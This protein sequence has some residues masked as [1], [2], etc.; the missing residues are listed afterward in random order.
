M[1]AVNGFL[2]SGN[3]Y[4]AHGHGGHTT[5]ADSGGG[6]WREYSQSTISGEGISRSGSAPDTAQISRLVSNGNVNT[7]GRARRRSF[8][9]QLISLGALKKWP[10]CSLD[11]KNA[12]LRAAGF[13]REVYL[14]APCEWDSKDDRQVWKLRAPAYARKDA[15]VAVHRSLR[16]YL[17][18]S[19]GSLCSAGPRFELSSFG[20]RL[21]Y[22]FRKSWGAVGAI[23]THIDNISGCGA[24]DLL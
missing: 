4:S 17:V 2:A 19:A 5:D 9:M 1:G 16:K 14:R 12:F 21:Y 7:T 11:I 13:D 20:R 15:P 3:G 18:A 22:F 24:T 6:G 10:L 8:H 23:T